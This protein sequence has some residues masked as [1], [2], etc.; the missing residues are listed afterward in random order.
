M[1]KIDMLAKAG[2]LNFKEPW[3]LQTHYEVIMGSVAYG[4]SNDTSDIDLYA[5][6]TPPKEMIFPHMAGHIRGFGPEP[7]NFESCQQHHIQHLDKEYDISLYSIVN[8]FHL[9]ADNN[10]NMIDSLFVPGRCVLHK[11]NVGTI[12][13]DN[14]QKFLHKGAYHRYKGYA[15]QQLKKI[16][17]K[18]SDNKPLKKIQEFE[19][20][21]DISNKTNMIDILQEI[22]KRGL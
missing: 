5:V 21:H 6:C 12:L 17:T 1:S 15:Y 22:R 14:R 20:I 16:K 3:K 4:V 19:K 18:N 11:D 8:Y 9:C 7:Q 10:P 13:R 2:L